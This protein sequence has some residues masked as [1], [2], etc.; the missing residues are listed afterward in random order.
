M[1]DSPVPVLRLAEGLLLR[2]FAET[3]L[4]ALLEA[5]ADP[6]VQNWNPGPDG[7]DPEAAAR[8]W[9]TGRNDWSAGSHASWALAAADGLLLGS[10][11]LHKI[12]LDQAD[13]EI[14]YWLAPWARGRGRA[15]LAVNAATG[16]AF[17]A[18]GLHRVHLFHAVENVASCR[19]ATGAGYGLE[20]HLR[21]SYR[22]PDGIYRDEHLHARLDSDPFPYAHLHG[23]TDG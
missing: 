20:G 4:S 8:D 10:V 3:D 22:Y 14:G 11:S 19:V 21:Q 17:D 5:F 13:A 23:G 2:A 6:A 16:Y 15:T 9:M 18:L 1:S 12:D 7:N